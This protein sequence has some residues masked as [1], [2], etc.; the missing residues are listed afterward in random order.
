M[1]KPL[2]LVSNYKE[3]INLRKV[4]VYVAQQKNKQSNFELLIGVK[5][6]REL[7]HMSQTTES[8]SMACP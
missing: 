5:H 8:S 4:S 7:K 3:L 2:S 6:L 1:K